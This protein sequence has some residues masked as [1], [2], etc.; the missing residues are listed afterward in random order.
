MYFSLFFLYKTEEARIA[1]LR[2]LYA[3]K[4]HISVHTFFNNG[5]EVLSR[6]RSLGTSDTIGLG[7]R[8]IMENEME[9]TLSRFQT[10]RK[11]QMQ[12]NE[13]QRLER[14]KLGTCIEADSYV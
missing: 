2:T 12:W 1:K 3:H 7:T 4:T 6:N 14:K 13:I 9:M 5:S 8:F 10:L 11:K